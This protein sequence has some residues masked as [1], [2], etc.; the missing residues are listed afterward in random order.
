M[1]ISRAKE[2]SG[3]KEL[4][5][6]N[7]GNFMRWCKHPAEDGENGAVDDSVKRFYG[8]GLVVRLDSNHRVL[9]ITG[10]GCRVILTKNSGSVHIVGDGCRLSVNHNVGDIEYTGDGGRVLLGPDSS[11]ENI[12]FVGD[13]G[14]VIFDSLPEAAETTIDYGKFH[15]QRGDLKKPPKDQ[16]NEKETACSR[17]KLVGGASGHE[18]SGQYDEDDCWRV[19]MSS[20]S[21]ERLD[22]ALNEVKERGYQRGKSGKYDDQTRKSLRRQVT[23]VTK[24]VTEIHGDGRCVRKRCNGDSSLIVNASARPTATDRRAENFRHEHRDRVT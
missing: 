13:G 6:K 5:R 14:K 9:E 16:R 3:R 7:R 18:K 22:N 19:T 11:K 20:S 21:R 8:D 1:T 15:C 2:Q 12:R 23:V 4:S 24:I 17:G 10:D